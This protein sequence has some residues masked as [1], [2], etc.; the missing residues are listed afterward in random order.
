[1]D[2]RTVYVL[3]KPDGNTSVYAGRLLRTITGGE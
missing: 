2:P 3:L 1:M